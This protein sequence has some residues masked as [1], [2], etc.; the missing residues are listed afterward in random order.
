ML[1]TS[2]AGEIGS[3]YENTMR[4]C[5]ELDL[6]IYRVLLPQTITVHIGIVHPCTDTEALYRQYGP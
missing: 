1:V 6:T 5:L 3:V 2:L 4:F